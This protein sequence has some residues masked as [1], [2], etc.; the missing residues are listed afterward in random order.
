MDPAFFTVRTPRA[1]PHQQQLACMHERTGMHEPACMLAAA[2]AAGCCWLLLVLAA[3][4]AAAAVASTSSQH[5]P[6]NMMSYA[7]F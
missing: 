4:A 2:A 6:A 7:F 3:T 1:R 5:Q